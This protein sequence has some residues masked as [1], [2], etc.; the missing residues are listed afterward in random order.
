VRI[1]ARE[2]EATVKA[3]T[4]SIEPLMIVVLGGIVIAMYVPMFKIFELIK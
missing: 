3:L 2:V 1:V 4:S